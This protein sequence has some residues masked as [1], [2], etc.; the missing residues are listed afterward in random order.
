MMTYTHSRSKNILFRTVTLLSVGIFCFQLP[1]SSLVLCFGED[2]HISFEYALNGKCASPSELASRQ[3]QISIK[4]S[5]YNSEH[6]EG[7]L[8]VSIPYHD[9]TL[10]NYIYQNL[11][12]PSDFI[13]LLRY[14]IIEFVAVDTFVQDLPKHIFLTFSHPPIDSLQTV[15]LII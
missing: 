3:N 4:D 13:P 2:G 5:A 15:I 12:S 8:D 11:L 7:C 10:H 14:C 1:L 9:T 6:C